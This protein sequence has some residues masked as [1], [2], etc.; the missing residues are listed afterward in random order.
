LTHDANRRAIGE[1]QLFRFLVT[2]PDDFR[3]QLLRTKAKTE[4]FSLW[5]VPAR[6]LNLGTWRQLS[7]SQRPSCGK[8]F[9]VLL[10]TSSIKKY[11]G[12]PRFL[13]NTSI[14]E[15]AAKSVLEAER[16]VGTNRSWEDEHCRKLA[17]YLLSDV[18]YWVAVY[19]AR[20]REAC[21]NKGLF[22]VDD[23]NQTDDAEIDYI[24]RLGKAL[25]RLA[26]IRRKSSSLLNSLKACAED[27]RREN[28][29]SGVQYQRVSQ[30]IAVSEEM[31][32]TL[33]KMNR[34][35]VI[36]KPIQLWADLAANRVD[37]ASGKK[38]AIMAAGSSLARVSFLLPHT[39]ESITGK[40]VVGATSQIK[41]ALS[42]AQFEQTQ[43]ESKLLPDWFK[44][45]GLEVI[46]DD[47]R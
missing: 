17:G 4:F 15:T 5:E 37:R 11:P 8:S 35:F 6:D 7:L 13:Y 43:L 1:I 42:K 3:L 21:L 26:A 2:S 20:Y 25:R 31:S 19:S 40:V 12:I 16:L 9:S 38:E 18:N 39:V 34:I 23:S 47:G 30:Y 28:Q 27:L 44:Q 41:N 24:H 29:I 45:A 36:D 10:A 33:D 22:F 14:S 32:R 46:S